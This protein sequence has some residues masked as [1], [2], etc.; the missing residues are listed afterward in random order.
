VVRP[1]LA[2][3]LTGPMAAVLQ[4]RGKGI[5]SGLS[6]ARIW[7]IWGESDPDRV[8]VTLV[9][10]QARQ[11]PG[12][13]VR[14]LA[15]L[16]SQEIRRRHGIP[17]TSPSRTLLDL[18]NRLTPLELEAAL[19]NA[20][21]M[22]LVRDTQIR[23]T[24][25][26]APRRTAGIARLRDLLDSEITARDT[27]SLYERKLLHLIH[28]AELPR[29][30]TN[31]MVAG[32]MVDMFWPDAGLVVEFDSWAFHGDRHAF[33]RDRMRDQ[34]LTVKGLTA[35]RVTA[36]QVDGQSYA[37]IARLAGALAALGRVR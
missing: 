28:L 35:I 24:L 31:V 14:R 15:T 16:P 2:D 3:G 17:L 30:V 32:H 1:G 22:R 23:Q 13:R 27:R 26:A 5:I 33:E 29:P 9:G 6:A 21:G 19:A 8:E 11:P 34:D 18:A 7:R 10:A 20:R 25:A 37:T 4:L 12:L 36:R